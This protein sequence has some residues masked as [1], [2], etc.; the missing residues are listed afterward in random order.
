MPPQRK[1][2]AK[3]TTKV[4][5]NLPSDVGADQAALCGDFNEWSPEAHPMK[6]FK[7]G[8]F[9]VSVNLAEGSYRYRF[10][11]NGDKWENDWEADEY[12][13]N[14]YGGEDSVIRV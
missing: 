12:V 1:P 7:D 11:I 5:F 13:A 10:L 4:T 2:G 3:G 8:H 6:K 14:P 9:S